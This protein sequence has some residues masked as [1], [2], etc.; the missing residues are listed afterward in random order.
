MSIFRVD[1]MTK[2]GGPLAAG[3][4]AQE[5]KDFVHR[6]LADALIVSGKGTGEAADLELLKTVRK[7][8]PDTPLL[9]GS[10]A[11]PETVRE[12][13]EIADGAIVGTAIKRD[14]KVGNPVDPARVQRLVRAA[15]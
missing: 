4:P 13:F 3:D 7:A 8:V 11:T 2:H 15:R 6:E 1:F 12:L 5:A 14:G 10:G 9:V